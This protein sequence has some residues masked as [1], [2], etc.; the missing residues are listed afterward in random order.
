MRAPVRIALVV[1]GVAPVLYGVA[2]LSGGWLG[3]PPRCETNPSDTALI[4]HEPPPIP[5]VITMIGCD[6]PFRGFE[7]CARDWISL[8]TIAV[9]T[10]LIMTGA[11]SRRRPKAKSRALRQAEGRPSRGLG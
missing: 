10:G 8:G 7:S 11:L 5:G 9:G 2:R 6:A 1:L 3:V 4:L